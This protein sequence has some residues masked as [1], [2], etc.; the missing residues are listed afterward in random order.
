MLVIRDAVNR[1]VVNAVLVITPADRFIIQV[2]ELVE[3]A[4]RQE[5]VFYEP[6]SGRVTGLP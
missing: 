2:C 5:V 3:D 6:Y 1:A 4:S